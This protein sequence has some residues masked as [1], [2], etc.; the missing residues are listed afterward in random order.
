[1]SS[2][3]LTLL[4]GLTDSQSHSSSGS[5][6]VLN[7]IIRIRGQ[8]IKKYVS[9]NGIDQNHPLIGKCTYAPGG[10]MSRVDRAVKSDTARTA[11]LIESFTEG[12]ELKDEMSYFLDNG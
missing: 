7:S 10:M 9:I 2:F 11:N 12:K 1:M 8:E 4:E 3:V 5:C 6:V